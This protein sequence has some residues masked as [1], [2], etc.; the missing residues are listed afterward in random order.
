MPRNHCQGRIPA[1]SKAGCSKIYSSS[2]GNLPQ[3]FISAILKCKKKSFFQMIE[4]N[5]LLK[6]GE[7]GI[8]GERESYNEKRNNTILKLEPPKS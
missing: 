6:E 4:G 8:S 5:D 7:G 1:S 2:L 3:D